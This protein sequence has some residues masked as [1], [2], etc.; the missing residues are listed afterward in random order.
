MQTLSHK[1]Q[2]GRGEKGFLNCLNKISN[3]LRIISKTAPFENRKPSVTV[4]MAGMIS[5]YSTP[6]SFSIREPGVVHGEVEYFLGE[7][8]EIAA[9]NKFAYGIFAYALAP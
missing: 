5:P 9:T 7:L 6:L 8:I 1:S 3:S 2:R 4:K